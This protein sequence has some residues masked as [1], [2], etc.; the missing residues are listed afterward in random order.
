MWTPPHSI[1]S[2]MQAQSKACGTGMP[3]LAVHIHLYASSCAVNMCLHMQGLGFCGCRLN[4]PHACRLPCVQQ[5]LTC[6]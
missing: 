1:A 6:F 4:V 5:W 2:I 3:I